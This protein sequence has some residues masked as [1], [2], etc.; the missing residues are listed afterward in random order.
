[1]AEIAKFHIEG[2]Q[3]TLAVFSELVE[4]IGDK[5][6]R[7][8]ILTPAVKEA[9]KPV[10]AMAK[11]TAPHDTNLLRDS[12]SITARR[13]TKRDQKS[14]Y[15][16][17]NDSVI[18]IVSTRPIPKKLK[19]AAHSAASAFTGKKYKSVRRGYFESAGYFYDA[20]AIANEFGTANRSAKPFLRN[21]LES[22]AQSVAAK[23]GMILNEK[24]QQYKGKMK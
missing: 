19:L 20:R 3:D 7:S 18:A 24:M 21:A 8:K 23:L 16:N 9:M 4:Q 5:K 14:M 15:V 12:L 13:P 17:P 22:Q 10:L 6:G 2:L 1:M 11:A